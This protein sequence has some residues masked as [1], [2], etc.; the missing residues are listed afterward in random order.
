[1]ARVISALQKLACARR[2]LQMR[3]RVYPRWVEQGRITAYRAAEEIACMEAIVADY[4]EIAK[5][6]MLL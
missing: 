3:R 4:E 2:E 1:M 5:K 6:E